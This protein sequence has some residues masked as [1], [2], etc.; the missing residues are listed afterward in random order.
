[1]FSS[2]LGISK[3]AMVINK[4]ELMTGANTDNAPDIAKAKYVPWIGHSGI[5][6]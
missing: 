5:S 1:M 3:R 2:P 4:Y 6:R